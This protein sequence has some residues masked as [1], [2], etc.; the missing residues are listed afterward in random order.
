MGLG[1]LG[2]GVRRD[3]EEEREEVERKDGGRMEDGTVSL[4][5]ADTMQYGVVTFPAHL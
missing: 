4:A 1:F 5:R 3:R 2:L